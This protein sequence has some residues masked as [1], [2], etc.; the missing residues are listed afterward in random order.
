MDMRQEQPKLLTDKP[1][2][3]PEGARI[4]RLDAIERTG[5]ATY[6]ISCSGGGENL[7]TEVEVTPHGLATDHDW[8]LAMLNINNVGSITAAVLKLH[9]AY[10]VLDPD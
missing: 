3:W 4:L 1:E 7:S 6:R 2:R 10:L 5:S 9:E 8:Q